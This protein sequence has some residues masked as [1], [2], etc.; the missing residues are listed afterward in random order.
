MKLKDI[1]LGIDLGNTIHWAD[2]VT[3]ERVPMP[4]SFR[5][6]KDLVEKVQSVYIVSRVSDEQSMRAYKWFQ[7]FEFFEKT[8]LTP[9]KVFFC[10]ERWDKGPICNRLNVTHFI[11]DRPEVMR[12]IT[13][14]LSRK[15]LMNP[16]EKDVIEQ[17]QQYCNIVKSWLDVEQFFLTYP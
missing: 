16:V 17:G 8:G 2:P 7:K 15:L 12:Y 1:V 6:I 14:P 9:N 10:Y 5:V 3:R 13:I 11:D 4:D